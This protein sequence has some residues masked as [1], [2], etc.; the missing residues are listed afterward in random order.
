MNQNFEN[1]KPTTQ[2]NVNQ[3]LDFTQGPLQMVFA[4]LFCLICLGQSSSASAVNQ[5]EGQTGYISNASTAEEDEVNLCEQ[6]SQDIKSL[7]DPGESAQTL[8]L[9][10]LEILDCIDS[11]L[12]VEMTNSYKIATSCKLKIDKIEIGW[13]WKVDRATRLVKKN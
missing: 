6:T 3:N 7:C 12:R 11:M 2:P 8:G 9:S 13:M 5:V 1:Q 4:V 10:R